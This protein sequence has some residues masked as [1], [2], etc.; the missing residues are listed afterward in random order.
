[1]MIDATEAAIDTIATKITQE[2]KQL[3][4]MHGCYETSIDLDVARGQSRSTLKYLL[5]R[6]SHKLHRTFPEAF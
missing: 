1:M 6:I 4:G 2:S 3:N 5:S